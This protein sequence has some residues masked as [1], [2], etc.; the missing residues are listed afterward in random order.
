MTRIWR[1]EAPLARGVLF[2]PLFLLSLLYRAALAARDAGGA[3][4]FGKAEGADIPVI[5][6]GNL[7]MGGTGKTTVVE[8]LSRE[9]KARGFHPGIVMLG[10][11]KKKKGAFAVDGRRDTAE[12]AGD[13]AVMLARRTML[14]V[15]VGKRRIVSIRRGV[16][17]FG[18]DVAIF[19]DGF[20]VRNVRKDVETVILAGRQPP[21]AL[22]LFPLGFL[23]EPLEKVRKADII[24]VTKGELDSRTKALTSGIRSFTSGTGPFTC[25]G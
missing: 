15:L 20:Q 25:A 16:R 1:N 9:L 10:Y 21:S 24:F 12:D 4:G 19:D 14:P 13:E 2:V 3:L 17:D 11:R 23:R 8:R 18:I 7:S 6:V 22:H 5:S